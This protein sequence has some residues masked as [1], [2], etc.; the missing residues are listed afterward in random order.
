MQALVASEVRGPVVSDVDKTQPSR[1]PWDWELRQYISTAPYTWKSSHILPVSSWSITSASKK[2]R[3]L[4]TLT[5]ESR[6]IP[7]TSRYGSE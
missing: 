2:G 5:T 6:L 3:S 4:R 1:Y 7:S